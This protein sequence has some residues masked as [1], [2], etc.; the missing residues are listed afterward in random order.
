VL[1]SLLLPTAALALPT[2]LILRDMGLIDTRASVIL[3]M[4]MSPFGAYFMR[5][6]IA[7]AIPDLLLDSAR[8]DGAGEW[9]IVWAIAFPIALPGIVT[10]FLLAFVTSWNNFLL[11]LLT[12]SNSRLF[13]VILGLQSFPD[14]I[15]GSFLSILPV[16]ALFIFLRRFITAGVLSGGLK[17]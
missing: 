6:Y 10:V 8:V 12:L 7:G 4:I 13:P 9:R 2:F 5:V 3:P 15:M 11:P 14:T 1:V 17:M 16:I